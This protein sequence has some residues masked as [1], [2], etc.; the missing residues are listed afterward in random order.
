MLEAGKTH[1][2]GFLWKR[3]AGEMCGRTTRDRVPGCE[4]DSQAAAT[5]EADRLQQRVRGNCKILSL[6][7]MPLS[8]DIFVRTN[9]ST[10]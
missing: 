5:F 2:A 9:H 6:E 4:D 7:G 1:W 8:L 3:V 10:L